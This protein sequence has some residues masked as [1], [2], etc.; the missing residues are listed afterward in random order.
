MTWDK[1]RNRSR[2][3]IEKYKVK[4]GP[5]MTGFMYPRFNFT[6]LS[7]SFSLSLI[8]S[9]NIEVEIVLPPILKARYGSAKYGLSRYDPL[10][11]LGVLL[12]DNLTKFLL[13]EMIRQFLPATQRGYKYAMHE[14]L[15]FL[16]A[17]LPIFEQFAI[18]PVWFVRFRK[19]EASR[20]W[21]AF[22]DMAFFDVNIYPTNPYFG[23]YDQ[24][25]FDE[26][27]YDG[28]DIGEWKH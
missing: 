20:N 17:D 25:D 22:Y 26:C 27:V 5:A 13:A 14:S 28:T 8:I 12:V 2:R 19:M 24:S 6:P 11:I 4:I 10:T 15:F 21:T 9:I 18:D 23:T 16:N 7:F 1:Y 3:A